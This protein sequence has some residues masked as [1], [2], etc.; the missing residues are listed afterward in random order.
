[1]KLT[2]SQLCARFTDYLDSLTTNHRALFISLMIVKIQVFGDGNHRTAIHYIEKIA[3][4]F[5]I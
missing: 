2:T 3:M 5:Y 1:M 4:V